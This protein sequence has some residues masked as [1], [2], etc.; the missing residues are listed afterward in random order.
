MKDDE[1]T[2]GGKDFVSYL[3]E[4]P[5]LEI[6]QQIKPN[7]SPRVAANFENLYL[8]GARYLDNFLETRGSPLPSSGLP[9][10][11]QIY[12]ESKAT[13]WLLQ[14]NLLF[15]AEKYIKL[16]AESQGITC[17]W[18][19]WADL[20]KQLILEEFKLLITTQLVDFWESLPIRTLEEL[21]RDAIKYLNDS[22][23]ESEFKR[24]CD[25]WE[26]S[27]A[28]LKNSFNDVERTKKLMP[29]TTFCFGVFEKYKR[30]LPGFFPW[31]EF[32]YS[33]GLPQLTKFAIIN[34]ELVKYP[35]RGRGKAKSKN[36]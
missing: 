19:S 23:H 27:K 15:Q 14:G 5:P 4:F 6:W 1:L 10:E 32:R 28:K 31:A 8:W 16:E 35:G 22:I 9:E 7:L 30:K 13:L 29:W 18:Q 21:K 12:V 25:E 3:L 26:K 36:P 34:G 11:F 17:D 33:E 20:N 2:Q 24:S